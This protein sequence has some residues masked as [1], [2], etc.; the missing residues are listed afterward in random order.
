VDSFDADGLSAAVGSGKVSAVSE[1]SRL[2]EPEQAATEKSSPKASRSTF[3]PISL[4][5][6]KYLKKAFLIPETL[7]SSFWLKVILDR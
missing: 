7:V 1:P 3:Q 5:L 6:N 4:I 2:G